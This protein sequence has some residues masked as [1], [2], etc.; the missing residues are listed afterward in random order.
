MLKGIKRAQRR[1]DEFLAT[2]RKL[3][4]QIETLTTDLTSV[5]LKGK[6]RKHAATTTLKS[7][8]VIKNLAKKWAV[9]A[10]PWLTREIFDLEGP[11][12]SAPLARFKDEGSFDLATFHDLLSFVPAQ[13]HDELKGATE[14]RNSVCSS[15]LQPSKVSRNPDI[16][17]ASSFITS[18][19]S[20]VHPPAIS[21]NM[22]Q[23]SFTNTR[24]YSTD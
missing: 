13:Y 2:N 4:A 24:M 7:G 12:D 14:F 3:E 15:I 19:A 6:S 9:T 1:A 18:T 21:T 23:S 20:A 16:Y 8:E 11:A 22:H 5:R 10:S 17:S